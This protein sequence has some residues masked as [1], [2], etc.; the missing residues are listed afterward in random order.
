[1]LSVVKLEDG[2]TKYRLN[3]S[4]MNLLNT[5]PRKFDYKINRQLVDGTESPALSFGKAI[6]KSLEHWYTLPFGERNFD[7]SLKEYAEMLSYGHNMD[8]EAKGSAESIRQF[9]INAQGLNQLPDTDKRSMGQGV[10]M[11]IAYFKHY[12]NDPFV[13]YKH[14]GVPSVEQDFSFTLYD[15]AEFVIE[16][17]GRIDVILKNEHT[18][19]I[20]IADHKTTSALGTQFYSRLKPNHQYT[21]YVMGANVALGIETNLFMINGLQVAK[22]KTEFARQITERDETDF[23]ELRQAALDCILRYRNYKAAGMWPQNAP[24][25][26]SSYGSC[27]YLDVCQANNKLKE[28]VIRHKWGL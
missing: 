14:K 17:F 6:H 9:V 4:S 11:L 27:E 1:M 13:V 15:C 25:P 26:C 8:T 5:C 24:E 3:Y 28:T 19:I 23:E 22:T 16:Y 7:D 12:H 18:G 2:R 20:V 10:K 21:G